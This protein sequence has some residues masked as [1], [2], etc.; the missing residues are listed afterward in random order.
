LA[1]DVIVAGDDDVV[2][3]VESIGSI[4]IEV[5]RDEV[6]DI[7]SVL[8][9]HRIRLHTKLKG[10]GVA[11]TAS[12]VFSSHETRQSKLVVDQEGSLG[13]SVCD[14]FQLRKIQ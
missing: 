3:L 7:L 11:V 1:R 4:A 10:D 9:V 8:V 6:C 12:R 2:Q 13:N 5:V 14:R